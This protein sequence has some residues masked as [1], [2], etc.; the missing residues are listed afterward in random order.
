MTEDPK[1]GL[2]AKKSVAQAFG[3]KI[4]KFILGYLV[5]RLDE[6]HSYTQRFNATC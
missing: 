1:L 3:R 2:D 5:F 6:D 4:L